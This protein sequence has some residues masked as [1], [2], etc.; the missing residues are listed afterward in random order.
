MFDPF[1]TSTHPLVTAIADNLA[2]TY[3]LVWRQRKRQIKAADKANVQILLRTIFAN[4]AKLAAEGRRP[5]T[6]G[7]SLRASKRKRTR[8]DRRELSG[9]PRLLEA[10]DA[11]PGVL[12]LQKSRQKGIASAV[13]ASAG[14]C[15]T[16]R[17][18]R[19]R[20]DHFGQAEGRETIWLTKAGDRD[21]VAGTASRELIDYA[22]T[23]ETKRLRAEMATINEALRG[24]E[25]QMLPDGGKPAL[26]LLRELRRYF[27]TP[28][29]EERF[30]SGGRLFGGWWQ[31]LDSN[32][33]SAIRLAGEP[34][35]DLDF[36][37]MFLRLAY[38][39]A[40]ERPPD[41]DLYAAVPGLSDA[42]WRK[43]VKMTA[44]AM[45]FR[46]TRMARLPSDA[47]QH[48]PPRA[49][50]AHVR[51]AILTAHPAIAPI[52]ESG[53]GLRFMFLESQILVAAMLRLIS[54]GVTAVLPMHDGLM[55][56]Q[57]NAAQAEQA[58][59]DASAQIVGIELP[60]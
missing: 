58:M 49:S 45:F 31:D 7:V 3:E 22:D 30:D 20:P 47:K 11:V 26:T 5:L 48:L 60:I 42:R 59:R 52:F 18:F 54:Q 43:G 51:A 19:F 39:E 34:I 32:R 40:G 50:C 27:N 1:L 36:A 15:E 56:P 10:L 44:S 28:S 23:P 12:S 55:C 14:L 57:S 4:F 13:T 53:V 2:S 41:G 17:R 21:Y 16:I 24:A 46:T 25:M 8:Y 29:G 38:L 35:V 6:I 37:S 9:L 33:R